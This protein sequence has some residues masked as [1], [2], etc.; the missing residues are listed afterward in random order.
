MDNESMNTG[1]DHIDDLLLEGDPDSM[2]AAAE[3][4]AGCAECAAA[5]AAWN[6]ISGTARSLRPSWRSDMLWP[7]IDRALREERPK[8]RSHLW[9]IA[10]AVALT[11]ALGGGVWRIVHVRQEQAAF[12]RAILRQSALDQ[13]EQAERAHLKA[14]ET[15]EKVAEPM[16]EEPATPLMVSYK[17][18]L[19]L[20]DDAIA[21][22]EAG[23]ARNR[24]NA[25]LRKQL[26]A[27][28]LEKQNTLQEVL[29]EDS[30]ASNQ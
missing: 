16:L 3:H 4:A 26:L 13:V 15:L 28:Y 7:R 29:R 14:I 23:I 8:S 9:R 2:R 5:L 30:N 12:G 10:A 25:H 19:V 1:H 18:K 24:H 20:L 6:E 22:C 11:V 21:E 17:E 27:M